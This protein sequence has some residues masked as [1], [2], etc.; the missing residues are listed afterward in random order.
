VIEA[1]SPW[2]VVNTKPHREQLARGNLLR[3]EFN[4]Y[5]PMVR[6]QRSHAHKT[7]IVLR[8]LFPT[9]IF[10]QMLYSGKGAP[11][12]MRPDHWRPI[13]STQGVRTILLAG[14]HPTVIENAFIVYLK[15]LEVDGAI[16]P[17]R[18]ISDDGPLLQMAG[19]ALGRLLVTILD[20]NEKDRVFLLNI[21]PSCIKAKG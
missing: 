10:V 18:T 21:V 9:Y 6:K 17:P 5:C 1:C 2:M 16:V 14:T 12:G 20:T 15:A 4:A 19:T 8:P 11:D 13:L 7:E 3:Q